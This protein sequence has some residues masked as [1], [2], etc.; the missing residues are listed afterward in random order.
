[1]C[2]TQLIAKIYTHQLRKAFV[3]GLILL[4]ATSITTA[5]EEITVKPNMTTELRLHW[6][7]SRQ[8]KD[9]RAEQYKASMQSMPHFQ[10]FA[11]GGFSF[12]I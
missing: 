5:T 12:T 6:I 4:G 10:R 11:A 9:P 3:Q 1:M 7:V 2:P 8:E